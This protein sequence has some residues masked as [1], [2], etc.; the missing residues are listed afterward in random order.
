MR[1]SFSYYAQDI[2]KAVDRALR[3]MR[4]QRWY[5]VNS[6]GLVAWTFST[7]A[8]AERRAQINKRYSVEEG[9]RPTLAEVHGTIAQHLEEIAASLRK[10]PKGDRKSKSLAELKAEMASSHPDRGGTSAKFIAA[11]RRYQR[12]REALAR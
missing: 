12:A 4:R 11:H 6:N 8:E 2:S 5:V 10:R 3:G 1:S 9:P 7:R